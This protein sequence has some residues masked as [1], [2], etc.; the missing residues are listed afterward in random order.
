VCI[1]GWDILHFTF[2]VDGANLVIRWKLGV[3]TLIALV[4]LVI[5]PYEILGEKCDYLARFYKKY[6]WKLVAKF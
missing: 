1:L 5:Y 4:T 3:L 6:N 2:H